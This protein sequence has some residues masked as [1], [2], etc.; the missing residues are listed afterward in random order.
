MTIAQKLFN[1]TV[2]DVITMTIAALVVTWFVGDFNWGTAVGGI[3]GNRLVAITCPTVS[4]DEE[5]P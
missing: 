2:S 4:T 3:V 1:I 5:L